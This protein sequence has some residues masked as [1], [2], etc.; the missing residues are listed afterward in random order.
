MV[1]S[2]KHPFGKIL[3]ARM[4]DGLVIQKG[5]DPL[6]AEDF[7]QFY[8]KEHNFET[9]NDNWVVGDPVKI[10]QGM[11]IQWNDVAPGMYICD[12]ITDVYGNLSYTNLVQVP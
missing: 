2:A 6:I 11:T 12:Q 3:G 9:G 1:I 4:N 7:L 10:T 5:F 8:Y